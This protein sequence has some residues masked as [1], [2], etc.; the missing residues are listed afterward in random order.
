MTSSEPEMWLWI[1]C[2]Q[3]TLHDIPKMSQIGV[4]FSLISSH[5]CLTFQLTNR[6]KKNSRVLKRVKLI[7]TSSLIHFRPLHDPI[8]SQNLK[9]LPWDELGPMRAKVFHH[10]NSRMDPRFLAKYH[11]KYSIYR[12]SRKIEPNRTYLIIEYVP[13]V[14]SE[15]LKERTTRINRIFSFQ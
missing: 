10:R 15:R 11:Y 13:N 8:F 6:L 5:S 1:F 3:M 14:I 4:K 2:P 7:V 9:Q 12:N